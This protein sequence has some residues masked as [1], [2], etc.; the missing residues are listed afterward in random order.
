MAIALLTSRGNRWL[1]L[2]GRLKPETTL[3]QA[4]ARFDLLTRDMQAAHPEEWLSKNESGRTRV[5]AITVLPESETRIH[6]DTQ[7]AAYGVFGSGLRHRE[8]RAADRVHQSREHVAGAS[9]NTTKRDGGATCDR[10]QSLRGSCDS[11]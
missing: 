10:R 7:S 8:S 4:R 2:V 6:P 9:R 3:A 1:Y 11:Y 5:S